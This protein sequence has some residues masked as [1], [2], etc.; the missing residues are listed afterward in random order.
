MSH[1]VTYNW[2][3][4]KPIRSQ[5]LLICTIRTVNTHLG[6]LSN[7]IFV[8]VTHDNGFKPMI[9]LVTADRCT[10]EIIYRIPVSNYYTPYLWWLLISRFA[11]ELAC[12]LQ[13]VY[14]LMHLR[15]ESCFE[16]DY[17]IFGP[18]RIFSTKYILCVFVYLLYFI[19]CT[20][21]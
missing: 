15:W 10:L 18:W 17:N 3:Y 19:I 20:R 8:T 12:I 1:W 7:Q 14:E 6:L 5:Y 13:T 9:E 4:F 16:I 2:N 21:R 11:S